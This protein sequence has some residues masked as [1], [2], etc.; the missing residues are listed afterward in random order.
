MATSA[1]RILGIDPGLRR[2]GWG[3]I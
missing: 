3:V 1:I 2:T